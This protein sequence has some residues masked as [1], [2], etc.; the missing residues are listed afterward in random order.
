MQLANIA[1][2]TF[3]FPIAMRCYAG[4]GIKQPTM[5]VFFSHIVPLLNK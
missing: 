1:L 2:D 4:L 3:Q 5:L